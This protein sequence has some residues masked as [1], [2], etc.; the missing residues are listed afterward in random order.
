MLKETPK[1]FQDLAPTFARLIIWNKKFAPVATRLRNTT[2]QKVSASD[3]GY[4]ILHVYKPGD[5]RSVVLA[6][7]RKNDAG[8]HLSTIKPTTQPKPNAFVQVVRKYLVG[9]KILQVYAG[10]SPV[11]LVIEFGP[12]PQQKMEDEALVDGPDC[13][14]LDIEARPARLSIAKKSDHVPA[15]YKNV[16]EGYSQ[17]VTFFESFCE[18]S[19]D[20]TKTKRRALF[21]QGPVFYGFLDAEIPSISPNLESVTLEAVDDDSAL[22]T[23][24]PEL[25]LQKPVAPH[26]ASLEKTDDD[27]ITLQQAYNFIPTHVRR[28]AKTRLQFFER[29]VLKQKGDLP[30]ESDLTL[31]KKRAEGFRANIYRWPKDARTWFVPR[32]LIEEFMLP[33]MYELKSHEKPGELLNNAF[34]EIEKLERRRTELKVRIAESEKAAENFRSLLLETGA[35]VKANFEAMSHTLNE[36]I[37]PA[38]KLRLIQTRMIPTSAKQI[39]NMLE[40]SWTESAQKRNEAEEDIL[41]RNPFRSFRASTGEFIRVAKSASDGDSML[42]LMPAHHMWIHVLTGEG[43]HVWLEK[44]KK[45]KPSVA[46]IREASILAIHYSKLSRGREGEVRVARRSDIEKRK[47]LAIGKV[48]VR[49]CDTLLIRFDVKELDGIIATG[50]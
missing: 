45:E 38:E 42:R 50:L 36:N 39:C 8:I 43:S 27:G 37:S 14:I 35:E 4:L 32:E 34:S 49:R 10:L 16:A 18:W 48:I 15:R 9:R 7:I 6:S 3:E 46:A 17:P 44:P 33:A 13:L 40:I 20:S 31:L 41:K 47:D 21:E 23:P 19:T 11:S 30:S 26:K 25:Q 24:L 2:L 28:A 1:F 29:R 5:D 22:Q 12:L